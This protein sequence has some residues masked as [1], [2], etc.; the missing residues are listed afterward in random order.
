MKFDIKVDT[1]QLDKK[2]KATEE[3]IKQGIEQGLKVCAEETKKI[4]QAYID[5]SV[6]NKTYEPTGML[7]K[8]ITIRDIEW[9]GDV[10]T[11]TVYSDTT[12]APYAEFVENGSGIF[13]EDGTGRQTPWLIYLGQDKDG[14]DIFRYTR[15]IEPHYFARDTKDYMEDKVRVLIEE[16]IMKCIK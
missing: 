10:A 12:I 13:R 3:Q 11:V 5:D 16:E 6:G 15:G 4:E 1:K 9:D 2:I 8:S 7:R 14:N